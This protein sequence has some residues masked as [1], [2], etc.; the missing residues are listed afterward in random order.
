MSEL[1]GKENPM[2]GSPISKENITVR[3]LFPPRDRFGLGEMQHLGFCYQDYRGL[4]EPRSGS[5]G[6]TTKEKLCHPWLRCLFGCNMV[7][8]GEVSLHDLMAYRD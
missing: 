4:G 1:H 2:S 3:Y 6:V 7:V 8:C 5:P